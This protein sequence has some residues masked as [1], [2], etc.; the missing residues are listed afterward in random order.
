VKLF[1]GQLMQML[2]ATLFWYLPGMQFKHA[3]VCFLS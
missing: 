3:A 2:L 1:L